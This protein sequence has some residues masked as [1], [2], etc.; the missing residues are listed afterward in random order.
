MFH[1]DLFHHGH[2]GFATKSCSPVAGHDLNG[3][4][5]GMNTGAFVIGAVA[6]GIAVAIIENHVLRDGWRGVGTVHEH[7]AFINMRMARQ[8]EVDAARFEDRHDVGAHF[9]QLLLP[10]AVV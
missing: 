2:G 9:D 5:I 8:D 3:T 6:F 1:D 10:I 4:L 7:R